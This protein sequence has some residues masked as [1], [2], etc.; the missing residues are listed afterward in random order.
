MKIEYQISLKE[1]H[2]FHCN[3][4]AEYF[5]TV[6]EISEIQEVVEFA[7]SKNLPLIPIG[8]GANF[9]FTTEI[10]KAVFIKIDKKD[11]LIGDNNYVKAYSGV[12]WDFFVSFTL[13][14]LLYG[15]ENLSGIPGTVGASVVQN[16]GAYGVEVAQFVQEVEAFDISLNKF[17]VLDK[18]SLNFAYRD[19]IFKKNRGNFIVTSVTYSLSNSPK[20]VLT[21]RALLDFIGD[22]RDIH[23]KKIREA[24]L[25]IRDSKL[26]NH[27]NIGNAG[28]FFKNPE[29]DVAFF[30]SLKDLYPDIPFFL[31][32]DLYKIPAAW[33]IEKSGW[34]GFKDGSFGVHQKHALI[35]VNYGESKGSDIYNLANKI[36][37]SVKEKFGITLQPEVEIV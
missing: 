27:K 33:L 32:G 23:P 6:D 8:D 14:N 20:T 31:S 36:I 2:T 1:R 19:S 37:D 16:I 15:L 24:V 25:Q 35:L 7:N 17:V 34:R 28:S 26:P 12:D 4:I 10:V 9:L 3:N 18:N 22:S 21:Y 13:D 5:I 11:I 30:E 29:V